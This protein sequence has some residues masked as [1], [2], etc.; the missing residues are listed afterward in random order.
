MIGDQLGPLKERRIII[1]GKKYGGRSSSGNTILGREAFVENIRNIKRTAQCVIQ[2]GVVAGR[3]VTVVDTPGWIYNTPSCDTSIMDKLEMK[4]SVSLCPPGPHAILLTV[5]F[6][7]A[8]NK[9]FCQA[10]REHMMLFGDDVWR[11]TIVLFT[12]GDWLGDTTTEERIESEG[13]DLKWLLEKCGNRYHVF[14][15]KKRDDDTQ[16]KELMEK[17]DELVASNSGS[18]Y[19]MDRDV[20]LENA[21]K[22]KLIEEN[23]GK[24]RAKTERIRATLKE[25]YR[26][27]H[28]FYLTTFP[29]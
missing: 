16:V 3:H 18:C 23:A 22:K 9:L 21:E 14:N 19:E 1:L 4:L 7:S 26:G 11:H 20:A 24:L 17:I 27:K 10:V 6:G 28:I 8:F 13:E 25:L 2:Q 15:N 5:S 12:R 29:E